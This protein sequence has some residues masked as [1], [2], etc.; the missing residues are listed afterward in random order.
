MIPILLL[1]LL[2]PLASP[3]CEKECQPISSLLQSCSL[4]PLSTPWSSIPEPSTR[5]VTGLPKVLGGS[6]KGPETSVVGSYAQAACF[7]T[8]ARVEIN[9]C[10]ACF[11]ADRFE[12]GGGAR[13]DGERVAGAYRRDCKE[14]GYFANE[15]LAYPSTT[16]ASMPAQTGLG[17]SSDCSSVCRVVKSQIAECELTPLGRRFKPL[18]VDMVPSPGGSNYYGWLLFNR[19][20]AECMCTKPVLRRLSACRWCIASNYAEEGGQEEG[21]GEEDV[22]M[23]SYYEADCTSLGYWTDSQEVVPEEG[24]DEKDRGGGG[25]VPTSLVPTMGAGPTGGPGDSGIGRVDSRSAM[26]ILG[27]SLFFSVGLPL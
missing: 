25:G 10:A 18:G 16:R 9:P 7:C 20:S 15:T 24:D 4:P 8:R 21:E 6:T 1:A 17:T 11:D 14:F 23:V 13:R 3:F 5:N 12:N 19:T 22:D 27:L 2:L 26:M